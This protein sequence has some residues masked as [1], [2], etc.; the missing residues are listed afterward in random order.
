V[1]DVIYTDPTDN[2]Y[3]FL[4]SDST[5]ATPPSSLDVQPLGFGVAFSETLDSAAEEEENDSLLLMSQ[6]PPTVGSVY[7][8]CTKV[9][10][11]EAVFSCQLDWH[12]SRGTILSAGTLTFYNGSSSV[13]AVVGGTG[14]YEGVKGSMNHFYKFTYNDLLGDHRN[15]V[16]FRLS[17]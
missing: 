8:M 16:S 2:E 10:P 13:M 1:A 12:F 14:I 17:R 15:R 6:R 9:S 5:A 4:P 3:K 11:Y 7:G